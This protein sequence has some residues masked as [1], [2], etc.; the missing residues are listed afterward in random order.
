M[1]LAVLADWRH[2]A[3]RCRLG[4]V[5]GHDVTAIPDGTCYFQTLPWTEDLGL[6]LLQ[7]SLW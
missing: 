6:C 2:A 7:L 3:R 5:M 1:V 4:R